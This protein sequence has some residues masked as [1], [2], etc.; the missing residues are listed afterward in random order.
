LNVTVTFLVKESKNDMYIEVGSYCYPF[1]ILLP[2]N[3]PTSFE[4][5]YGHIRYSLNSTIS[6]P[7]S[8]DS[9]V[10]RSFTVISFS[11]LNLLGPELREPYGVSDSFSIGCWLCRS[12]PIWSK[13][14]IKK[15]KKES[16]LLNS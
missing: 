5:E 12:E 8:S 10:K 11:D 15:S 4:H 9:H 16:Q 13:F 14:D 7:W 1:K 2:S 3:L 6:I